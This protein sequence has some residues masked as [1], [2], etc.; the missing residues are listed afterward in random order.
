MSEPHG[1]QSKSTFG[2]TL[3]RHRTAAG[4][5]QAALA[6]ASGMSV[7]ALR[8]LEHGRAAAAQE[9]STELLADALGLT[10]DE[11]VSFVVLATQKRR[12]FAHGE[13][14]AMLY[15]LP[16]TPNVVGREDELRRLSTMAD[17]GGVVVVAGPPGVGK[18]TLAVAAADH[19]MSR[20][21]DGSLAL[22]LRGVG[23][24]PMSSSVALERVLTSLG[25]PPGR[26]PPTQGERSSLFR[27]L[28]RDRSVLLIL[29]NAMDEAQ[30]KPLLAGSE[31]S[32]TIV[33]C[34]RALA[35]LESA[36]RLPI[37]MLTT[38]NAVDLL[39]SIVG[40]DVVRSEP[41]AADELVSLCGNLPLA[42]RIVGNRLATRR[43]SSIAYL[44]GRMRD[45]RKRLNSLSVGDLHVRA[46][47]ATSLQ[48][49]GEGER[50]A[51]RRLA[52]IP[53]AHFDDDLAAVATGTPADEIG[54]VLDSLVEMSL[55]NVIGDPVRLQFHDLVRL[56]AYECRL[57]EE[58]EEERDRLR[59]E[60]YA[61]VLSLGTAAGRL[62]L[63]TVREISDDCPFRSQREAEDWL[64]EN[65]TTW[66]EV[67]RE[68]V[69]LGW[70]EQVYDFVWS[71]HTYMPGREYGY[72]WNKIFECGLQA[73]RALRD[74]VKE[75]EMLALMGWTL[76]ASAGE[77]DRALSVL[78]EALALAREIDHRRMVLASHSALGLT[79]AALGRPAEAVEH[80]RQAYLVSK[81]LGFFEERLWATL[82]FGTSLLAAGEF[83]EALEL[84]SALLVETRDRSD[85]TNHGLVSK[86][87]AH[88]LA[89]TG[90]SFA[91]LNRWEEAAESYRA[92]RSQPGID[93]AR[94]RSEAELALSE[95]VAW[96]NV[97]DV[98]RARRCLTFAHARLDGPV[99]QSMRERVEAELAL[100]PE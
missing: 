16:V 24:Q 99:N 93:Q 79:S 5:S 97:G 84:H 76:H 68:A 54:A 40:D 22:D 82:S 55:I 78:H 60:L 52:I 89:L 87:E 92:A 38:A 17:A 3:L 59:D 73:A 37:D 33:T 98:D 41:E 21:S 49:L 36:H 75:A 86:M 31:H 2:Q 32:L 47:F 9:R 10:G 45:Q 62:F 29:D 77:S 14:R 34:R 53:G 46:A 64:E 1:P 44:V 96:R 4:L 39:A 15:A 26:I 51:F 66:S 63:P 94:Y 95:G 72:G 88:L 67:C 91:G 83:Q 50:S 27:T 18:T 65:V 57:D 19:L 11:R 25:V 28:L 35:G 8:D 58:P 48:W 6:L 12:R 81:D 70:H 85:Q 43:F 13:N 71:L 30:V 74:R 100:L 80:S 90:D 20:F 56:F 23:N 7:R 61:H 42:V 69:Q